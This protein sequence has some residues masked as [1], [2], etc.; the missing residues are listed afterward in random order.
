M[1]TR[2]NIINNSNHFIIL[3][4][5]YSTNIKNCKLFLGRD[6]G[7]FCLSFALSFGEGWGEVN[8]LELKDYSLMRQPHYGGF[9]KYLLLRRMLVRR[10]P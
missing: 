10:L 9:S 6:T 3:S 7:Y 8:C 5:Y 2:K 1:L 4:T